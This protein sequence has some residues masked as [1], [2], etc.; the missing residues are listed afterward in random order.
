M[1][2]AVVKVPTPLPFLCVILA[3]SNVNNLS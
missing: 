3:D 1:A 2:L